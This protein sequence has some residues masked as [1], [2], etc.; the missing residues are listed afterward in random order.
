MLEDAYATGAFQMVVVYGRRRVGKSTLLRRFVA[1]KPDVRFFQARET[2]A[3]ENLRALSGVILGEDEADQTL[4]SYP[5]FEAALDNA[6]KYAEN[7]RLIL[8][9]DEYPSTSIPISRNPIQESPRC[10]R[11]SSTAARNP[12]T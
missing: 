10:S 11:T 5:T 2:I 1:D 8:V 4:P 6:F 12:P 3:A 9:I 7:H